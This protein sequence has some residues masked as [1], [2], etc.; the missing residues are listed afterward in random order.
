MEGWLSGRKHLTANEAVRNG[1][2]VRISH[3]P[4]KPRVEQRAN[5]G[6]RQK[7]LLRSPTVQAA[8]AQ[9][10]TLHLVETASKETV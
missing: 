6:S 5:P 9:A 8:R 1:T 3:L 10:C 4:L 2:G 7:H